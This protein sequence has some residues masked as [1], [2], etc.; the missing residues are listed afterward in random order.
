[1]GNHPHMLEFLLDVLNFE[2][3]ITFRDDLDLIPFQLAR[4]GILS[5]NY[6]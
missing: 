3:N 5:Q 6:C 1:M 4:L 2:P